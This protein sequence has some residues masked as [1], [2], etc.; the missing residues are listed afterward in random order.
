MGLPT[1]FTLRVTRSDTEEKKAMMIMQQSATRGLIFRR[2]AGFSFWFLALTT[3]HGPAAVSQETAEDV[4]PNA[5][6]N[7]AYWSEVFTGKRVLQVD[8]RLTAEAWEKMQPLSRQGEPGRP[9]RGG[10]MEFSY[11]RATMSIDGNR[12]KDVGLRFKGNSSYRSSQWGLRRP[13]KVDT[14]RFVKGLKWFG[15]TKLNLS[16]SFKDATLLREKLGYEVFQAAGLPTPGVGW[17]HVTLTVEGRHESQDLGIYV[18]IEQV[19][20]DWIKRKLGPESAKSLL[21]KP[22]GFFEWPYLGEELKAYERYNI[23]AGQENT[24]LRRRFIEFVRLL[25]EGESKE[26]AEN[27][28]DYLDLDNWAQ[29]FAANTLLV[30]LDSIVAMPHNYYLVVDQ[31]DGLIKILPWDLNECFGLFTAG[32]NP[33]DLVRWD[34]KRPWVMENELLDRLF[35]VPAFQQRYQAAVKELLDSA[36]R[37]EA[38][39][40][41]I[42]EFQPRLEAVMKENGLSGEIRQMRESLEA[43]Q[44]GGES[45]RGRSIGL[46]YFVQ[47]RVASVQRQLA[48]SEQ[49]VRI[50]QGRRR[51]GPGFGPPGRGPQGPRIP[52]M[53]VIETLDSDRDGVLSA[54]E[55]KQAAARLKRL[56]RDGDGKLSAA[57]YEFDFRPSGAGPG[58]PRR[59]R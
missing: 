58:F 15:R 20:D 27:A 6:S 44:A 50:Q 39:N 16:N 56:D 30:N 28:G 14:N 2:L 13:F 7:S 32:A 37:P 18:L 29:Y 38:I 1:D 12:L 34:I 52:G 31:A 22:E 36:F 19:D 17:A 4:A 47:E 48:G 45:F 24:V 57:E 23:K 25:K 11:A 21:M 3:L 33:Q 26:F 46:K 10:E 8:L 49:G 42:A 43:R 40:R 59:P 54:E 9:P 55:I 5:V 41:R 53:K 51:G 35:E